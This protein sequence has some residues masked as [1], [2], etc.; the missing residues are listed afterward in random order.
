MEKKYILLSLEDP[1]SKKLS[2][3]LGNKTC[4]KIIDFLTETKEASEKDISDALNIPLSTTEYN[5]KK[6]VGA[7]LVEKT[8]NFF[9]AK[10]EKKFL[11]TLFQINL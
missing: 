4:K 11:C 1:K 9:G 8:K 5:L 6:L 10:K 7:D 3:V 2:E